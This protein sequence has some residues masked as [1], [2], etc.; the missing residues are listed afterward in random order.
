MD[1]SI[2][3]VTPDTKIEEWVV[4]YPSKYPIRV[5]YLTS[6]HHVEHLIVGLSK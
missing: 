2:L 1:L 4:A 3:K 6:W 5:G